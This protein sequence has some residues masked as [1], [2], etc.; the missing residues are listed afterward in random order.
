M[1]SII[2]PFFNSHNK[3]DRLI[4]S[5]ESQSCKEFEWIIVDDC[6]EAESL[7][8]LRGKI[9]ASKVR[10]LTRIVESDKNGG[11][12]QARNKGI[13][14]CS[15]SYLTFVDS[16]DFVENCFVEDIL[17]L[18]NY[19]AD[20]LI[21][22]S[23]RINGEKITNEIKGIENVNKCGVITKESALERSTS[24]V[25][26]SIY[27]K[28]IID[29]NNLSFPNLLRF[30]DFAFKAAF[31]LRT[32]KIIYFPKR[33]Y[34]YVSNESSVLATHK[35]NGFECARLAFEILDS[36]LR[37]YGQNT[38]VKLAS[39]HLIYTYVKE[40]ALRVQRKAFFSQ[41]SDFD[42]QYPGWHK[43]SILRQFRIH[44]RAFLKLAHLHFWLVLRLFLFIFQRRFLGNYNG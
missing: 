6:S 36:D 40:N 22:D 21:F 15:S 23:C 41:L 32:Q 20:M 8:F 10:G 24:M 29:N 26:G 25:W 16:D 33:L 44:Q 7:A 43:K 4:R 35:E 34:F 3:I 28:S 39:K 5:L 11:P 27:K 19:D 18:L 38:L 12:G 31:V 14:E 9:E 42:R 17:R 1:I 13:E 37:A 30:E 2:T